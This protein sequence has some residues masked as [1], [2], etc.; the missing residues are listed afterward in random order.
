M[1]FFVGDVWNVF[2]DCM[3]RVPRAGPRSKIYFDPQ[4]VRAAIVTCGGLCPGLNDVIRQVQTQS[5]SACN[6]FLSLYKNHK[7]L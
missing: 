4:E 2:C 3:C 5:V 6:E 7:E 1:I